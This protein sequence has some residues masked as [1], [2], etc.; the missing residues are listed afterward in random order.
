[1]DGKLFAQVKRF[2]ER[3]MADDVF[4]ATAR[5]QPGEACSSFGL[6]IDHPERLASLW[7]LRDRTHAATPEGEALKATE[8]QA[9]SYLAFCVP[10]NGAVDGYVRWRNR[11]KARCAFAQGYV[12][13]PI[14]LHL[15]YT[16]ELT[17]GCSV[18]CWFCGLSAQRLDGVLPTDI[19][20]WEAMLRALRGVFGESAVRGFL[21]WATDPLDHPDYEAY[22][23]A[24]ARVLGRF[25]ATTT[26]APLVDVERTRRLLEISRAGDCPSMR[27]SVISKRQLNEI[28][29]AFTAEELADVEL[30]PVNRESILGL[31]QAG[32]VR[33]K[34]G[35][36]RDRIALEK[37]KLSND[38]N[39]EIFAHRTIACVSGFLIE[40]VLGRVRL[41]SPEPCSDRWPDGYA[42]FDE[43]HYSTPEEFAEGI[44]GI[45]ER[46]MGDGPP[47]R[48]ALQRG[49]SVEARA[50]THIHAE[51]R[52]C[53]VDL[54]SR[55]RPLAHIPPLAEAF[56][57]GA[58]L[59]R[60][61][62]DI[63]REFGVAPRLVR[64]DAAEL[65]R[66]GVLIETFFS[67][68]DLPET[69]PQPVPAAAGAAAQ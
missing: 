7:H 2:R 24:F 15:P 47:A 16:V 5:H 6:E 64:N 58:D 18:G 44:N 31:A 49:V 68:A 57:G 28:H 25:P 19:P 59:E 14:S 36:M 56:R 63:A 8:S 38:E 48:L 61:V 51:A 41:I 32:H 21:Y 66:R 39:D 9:R 17:N 35:R 67:F 60:V 23:E 50:P 53:W 37:R 20:A 12:T 1:M 46:S 11:Q 43:A 69:T 34:E 22:G 62:G 10:D 13:A 52:G 26:A 45:V 3:W 40:P 33:E 65:W 4:R 27:F 55:Q 42:V 30:V 54:R 29:S